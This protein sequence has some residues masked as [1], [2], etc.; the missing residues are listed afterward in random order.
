MY[1]YFGSKDDLLYEIYA[2]VRRMQMERLEKFVS[3]ER[4]VEEWQHAAA[5]AWSSRRSIFSS[6]P[7]T[8]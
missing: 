4:P 8:S 3:Q 7:C 5:A 1:H 2:G 6:G